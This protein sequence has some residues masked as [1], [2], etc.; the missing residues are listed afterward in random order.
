MTVAIVKLAI[1]DHTTSGGL[2]IPRLTILRKEVSVKLNL[3]V[4]ELTGGFYI[5][6]DRVAECLRARQTW[7]DGDGYIDPCRISSAGT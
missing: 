6:R 5:E 3:V 1:L 7:I 4:R 2:K